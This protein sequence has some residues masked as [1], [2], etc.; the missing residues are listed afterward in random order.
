MNKRSNYLIIL[1]AVVFVFSTIAVSWADNTQCLVVRRVSP[2]NSLALA[3]VNNGSVGPFVAI[4]G[5]FTSQPT[6]I[7]DED[8]QRYYLYG[9]GLLGAVFRR[10]LDANCSLV[11]GWVKLTSDNFSASPIGA[12]GG[13]RHQ[14]FNSINPSANSTATT[15]TSTRRN[16]KTL[17]VTAPDDGFFVCRAGGQINHSRSSSVGTIFSRVYLV[18]SSAGSATSWIAT[19]DPSGRSSGFITF[20]FSIERWFSVSG[21]GF[22]TFYATAE[23]GGGAQFTTTTTARSVNMTCQYHPYAF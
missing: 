20:P 7:W 6:V 3:R 22:R 5:F 8:T 4:S 23:E 14:T 17:G 21:A 15:L 1:L 19:D 12:A 11:G 9:T 10:T 13:G 2:A 18:T 16:I